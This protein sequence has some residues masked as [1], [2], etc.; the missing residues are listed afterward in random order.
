LAIGADPWQ[1]QI[2]CRQGN[3]FAH[4]KRY[5]TRLTCIRNGSEPSIGWPMIRYS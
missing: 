1:S 4:F 5:T 2:V 3:R